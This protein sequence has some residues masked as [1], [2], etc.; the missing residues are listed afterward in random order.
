MRV[1]VSQVD[2]YKRNYGND[3]CSWKCSFRP[4]CNR[5]FEIWEAK[6]E[7]A[8]QNVVEEAFRKLRSLV[9]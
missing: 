1:M 6:K 2:C 4:E 8:Y 3:I 9:M 7:A 5:A